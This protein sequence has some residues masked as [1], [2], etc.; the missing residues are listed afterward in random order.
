[1]TLATREVHVGDWVELLRKIDDESVDC[2]VTS[3]PYWGL[4]DYGVDGQIG[5]EESPADYVQKLVLGF[6]EVRRVLKS[7]GTVW[8]NLGD[9]YIGSWGA[10]GRGAEMA[11]RRSIAA[12]QIARAA[13]RRLRT[14]E[15]GSK[16]EGLKPKDLV[17]I[18]WMV[19][20]GLRGDGW[21]LR[22]E[23]IWH[24]A[25]PT[26]ETVID[27]PCRDHEQVF[28]LTKSARYFYDRRAVMQKATG[29]AHSRVSVFEGKRVSVSPKAGRLERG[30]KSNPHFAA[31]TSK[32]VLE[33][34]NLRTVWKMVSEPYH[35]AHFATFPT[36]LATRCILAGCPIDGVVLDPFGGSGTVAEVAEALGRRW[37]H[38]DI[39]PEYAELARAR[40]SQQGLLV[41]RPRAVG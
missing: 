21:W 39:S 33:E 34:R 1:M 9:S 23:N 7:T 6:R 31:A 14:R 4:R 37:I 25:N 19:A 5:L 29:T 11:G 3:P 8:I 38:L 24:K 20:F 27:R 28:L 30:V 17:G 2:V 13:R 16:T 41:R 35:G 15:I 26:P 40:T 18:P 10:Q 36:K 32:E 12:R 22:S